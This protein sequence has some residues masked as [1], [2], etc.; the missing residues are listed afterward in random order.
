MQIVECI[1]VVVTNT[2]FDMPDSS[3]QLENIQR[4]AS[5]IRHYITEVGLIEY[6]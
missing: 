4:G 1:L 5:R 6:H 2:G 3:L